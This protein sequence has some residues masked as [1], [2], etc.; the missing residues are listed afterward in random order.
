M[1]PL[2]AE[3]VETF[4]A[5]K[6]GLLVGSRSRVS[7]GEVWGKSQPNPDRDGLGLGLAPKNEPHQPDSHCPTTRSQKTRKMSKFSVATKVHTPQPLIQSLNQA[8]PFHSIPLDASSRRPPPPSSKAA[9]T[10][11][12]DLPTRPPVSRSNV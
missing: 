12:A 5:P 11:T 4:T 9:D 6:Q 3:L 1:S 10:P 8:I 2:T 7:Q